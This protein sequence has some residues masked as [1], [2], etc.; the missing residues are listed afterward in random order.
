MPALSAQQ[1]FELIRNAT[2]DP[3]GLWPPGLLGAIGAIDA[4]DVY[5]AL[6][7]LLRQEPANVRAR[8]ARLLGDA[9]NPEALEALEPLLTLS[10]GCTKAGRELRSK[11]QARSAPCSFVAT[12]PK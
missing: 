8:A 1:A 7:M 10:R 3:M 12:M 5:R 11:I 6:A 2:V 9:Q 4:P